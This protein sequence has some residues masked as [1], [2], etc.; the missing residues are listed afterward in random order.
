MCGIT[1]EI[2]EWKRKKVNT[3]R[4]NAADQR[5]AREPVPLT[6]QANWWLRG[7]DTATSVGLNAKQWRGNNGPLKAAGAQVPP[8]VFH[9]AE[10]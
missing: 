8:E 7:R 6:T 5:C 4:A 1:R 3:A 2:R 10:S 9:A